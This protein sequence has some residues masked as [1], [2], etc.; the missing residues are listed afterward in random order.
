MNSAG[1]RVAISS[2]NNDDSGDNAGHVRVY[3][4][5][6]FVVPARRDIDGEAV[7]DY[8]GHYVSMNAAGDRVAIGAIGNDDGGDNAGHVR[9][10]QYSSGLGASFKVILMELKRMNNLAHLFP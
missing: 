10:Y 2:R 3:E 9:V 1:D 4:Y 7:N 5:L 8:S 6:R